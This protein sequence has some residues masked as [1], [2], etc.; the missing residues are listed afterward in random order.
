MAVF[1][2]DSIEFV[3]ECDM[4]PQELETWKLT[5]YSSWSSKILT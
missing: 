1:G 3:S 5:L 2:F 4:N